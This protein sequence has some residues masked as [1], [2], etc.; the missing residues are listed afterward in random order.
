[1]NELRNH[2]LREVAKLDLKGLQALE[3]VLEALVKARGVTVT[4]RGNGAA[5]SRKTSSNLDTNLSQAVIEG[6]EDRL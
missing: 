4:A 2:V 5:R 1:M 6:R 3:P